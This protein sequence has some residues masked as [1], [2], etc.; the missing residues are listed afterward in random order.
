MARWPRFRLRRDRELRLIDRQQ[1]GQLH[2]GRIV[3]I[4]PGDIE[5]ALLE[6]QVE[7]VLRLH[8]LG[9]RLLEVLAFDVDHGSAATVDRSMPGDLLRDP[10]SLLRA[11]VLLLSR[12]VYLSV[13]GTKLVLLP[14]QDRDD[15]ACVIHNLS[16]RSNVPKRAKL[17]LRGRGY[18]H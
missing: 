8:E 16:F 6:P 18:N 12:P 5:D 9:E 14:R 3:Q 10:E 13:E 15:E 4:K 17:H 7:L 11:V 1:V 2:L